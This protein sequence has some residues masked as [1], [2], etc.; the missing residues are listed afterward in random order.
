MKAPKIKVSP[1]TLGTLM[2]DFE[3][4]EIRVPRFQREFVWERSRILKLLDSMF[5]EFPIGTIFLWNAPPEYNYLLRSP[6]ELGLPELQTHQG[7]RFILDGQQRLTSLFVVIRGASFEGEDYKKIV[8]DLE[9]GADE[10]GLFKYRNPDN[11]RWAFPALA[12]YRSIPQP[13]L[14]AR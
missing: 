12:D 10:D 9:A 11:R 1:D 7:Y 8:V 14:R 5:K 4:G 3:K 6:K 2:A 13:C